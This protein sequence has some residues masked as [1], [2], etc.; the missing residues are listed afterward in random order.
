MNTPR[1]NSEG[2][3]LAELESYRI[4]DTPHER[5]FCEIAEVAAALLACPAAYVSFIDR[6][7]LWFKATVGFEGS[8]IPR[9]QTYCQFVVRD[10]RPLA[11]PDTR[12]YPGPRPEPL[13][14]AS[15]AVAE[16]EIRFYV[17]VP[18]RSAAGAVLGTLCAIDY[19]PRTISD[20]EISQLEKLARQVSAQLE[21]RRANALLNTEVDTFSTLFEAAPVPLVL[22]ADRRIVRC[23]FAFADLVCDEDKDALEGRAIDS[24]LAAFPDDHGVPLE[25][26]LAD[27]T[28]RTIPVAV[29]LTRLTINRHSYELVAVSNITDRR[30]REEMEREQRLQAEN[31]G[32]IKDTF[33]QLVAHDLKSPISGI[34]TVLDLMARRGDAFSPEEWERSIVDLR[35]TA[36]VLVEMVNQLLN[37]HRLQSG[38]VRVDWSEV[39]VAEVVSQVVMTLARQ[40]EEKQIHVESAVAPDARLIADEGLLREALFNLVVNAVKFCEPGGTV[41]IEAA[42]QRIAVSDNGVGVAPELIDDLF[43]HEIKTTRRGTADE[44]GTGFGLPLVADIMHAHGGT[45]RV[46]SP[47][48]DGRGARFELDFLT[49]R[50]DVD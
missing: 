14:A 44:P 32:R 24:I 45:V 8:E 18:I 13:E 4:L 11:I 35:S 40:I 7:R 9:E 20:D 26:E 42:D 48:A 2:A 33:L 15:G 41:V 19:E 47:L 10:D 21:L 38:E 28:G 5:D 49:E 29:V 34:F 17:G 12:L 31:A 39:A 43:R 3:R 25:T 16:R 46:R 1:T 36:A 30:K 6:D 27:D 50:A 37:I 22:A 23:N